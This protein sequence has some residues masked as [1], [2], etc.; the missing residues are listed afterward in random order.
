MLLCSCVDDLEHFNLMEA[1]D[2]RVGQVTNGVD[3][4]LTRQLLQGHAL[5]HLRVSVVRHGCLGSTRT[6]QVKEW[7]RPWPSPSWSI[8]RSAAQVTM[9]RSAVSAAEASASFH[10]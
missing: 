10:A 7:P 2:P 4:H 1:E 3:V 8:A 6:T 5:Q 9:G